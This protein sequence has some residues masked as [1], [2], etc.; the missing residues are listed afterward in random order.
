MVSIIIP[1][2]NKSKIIEETLQSICN[3]RYNDWECI[4]VDDQS[5]DNSKEIIETFIKNDKRFSFYERPN[6]RLKG[7]ST[8]RNIGVEKAIGHYIV[9]LDSDDLL[10]DYCLEYRI[11]TFSKNQDC[12]FL[13]F[14]MERF[15]TVPN[16]HIKKPL[17]IILNENAIT[18]FLELHSLWQVTSPIY[19]TVFVR[20]IKGFNEELRSFEDIEI[21]IK[22]ISFS[23]KYIS[24]NNIDSF[25]RNDEGYIVKYSNKSQFDMT[26]NSFQLFINSIHYNVISKVIDLDYQKKLKLFIVLGYKKLFKTIIVEHVKDYKVQNKFM[27]DFFCLN[28]YVGL[29]Q[30]INF[31]FVHYIL[32]KFY[33]I[34]GLGVFRFINFLYK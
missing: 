23:S 10:A 29:L 7:P 2:Y 14:Q 21:A 1:N 24:Y 19:K 30:R 31:Y 28:S 4:I 32:F 34:K 22:A 8:C 15:Q 6:E 20:K 25:Y 27:I 11:N 16:I 13:V 9:F 18:S 3:Q 17:E 33:K 12:D 5:N 26:I